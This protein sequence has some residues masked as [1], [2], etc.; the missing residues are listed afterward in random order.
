MINYTTGNIFDSDA[1]CIFNT[2]TGKNGDDPNKVIEGKYV[3]LRSVEEQ[4]AEFTLS[5]RQD[6]QL[7]KY[8]PKL[9][10]A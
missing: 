6:P 9:I 10:P 4:D 5:L 2:V 8:L 3:N 7:T 1:D